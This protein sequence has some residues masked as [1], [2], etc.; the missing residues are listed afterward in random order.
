MCRNSCKGTGDVFIA[1]KHSKKNLSKR[2]E[3]SHCQ[4]FIELQ[5]N[6]SHNLINYQKWLFAVI[7]E[8]FSGYLIIYLAED[9][10]K[11]KIG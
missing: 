6:N 3:N 9:Q 10:N 8:C 4:L 2:I 1:N 5:F 11:C 7:Y